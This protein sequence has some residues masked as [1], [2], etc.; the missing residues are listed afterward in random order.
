MQ[1]TKVTITN[2]DENNIPVTAEVET[3]AG[4]YQTSFISASSESGPDTDPT[5]D[6]YDP[7]NSVNVA[8]LIWHV[9]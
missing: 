9:L 6:I 1:I 7:T 3:D 8:Q 4:N 5:A 2:F